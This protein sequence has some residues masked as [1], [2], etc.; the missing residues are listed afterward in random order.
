MQ[1]YVRELNS[2]PLTHILSFL[3]LHELTAILPLVGFTAGFYY[4]GWSPQAWVKN[5][6]FDDGMEKFG[7]YFS[8]KRWFG[9]GQI[10][11]E[12]MDKNKKSEQRQ[13][14]VDKIKKTE[15]AKDAWGM[16]ISNEMFLTQ[17]ATAYAITKILLPVRIAA[18]VWMTPW[19]ARGVLG[20][21]KRFYSRS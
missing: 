1:P 16:V 8:K 10:E 7:K 20:N 12:M 2:A 15:Q 3:I 19:F 14:D 13:N 11:G 4:I 21:L 18:S 17:V 6:W 5:T 9:F